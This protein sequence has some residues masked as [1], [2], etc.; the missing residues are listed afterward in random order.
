MQLVRYKKYVVL[1][2]ET[3]QLS[4][5]RKAPTYE[6]PIELN[7]SLHKWG[8]FDTHLL[9]CFAI[10]LRNNITISCVVN[11]LENK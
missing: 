7:L 9:E 11:I 2:K 6:M 3:Y 8:N 4:P 10:A 5:T 1:K